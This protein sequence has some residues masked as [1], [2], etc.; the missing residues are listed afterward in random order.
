MS[1]MD[2]ED[3]I[4]LPVVK[5]RPRAVCPDCGEW[6]PLRNDGTFQIHTNKSDPYGRDEHRQ[7]CTNDKHSSNRETTNM[8]TTPG[9]REGADAIERR[10][11]RLQRELVRLELLPKD[12][13]ENGSV[14]SFDKS[15][16]RSIVYSYVA[17]K[18]ND[19]WFIS[20]RARGTD[21]EPNAFSWDSLLEF[22][23]S[24]ESEMPEIWYVSEWSKAE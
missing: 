8:A 17:I 5:R 16:G 14:I 9:Q 11:E 3:W 2:Y 21:R 20:G 4:D 18:A 24:R 12:D 15:F 13:Y 1:D 22:V 10:I 6:I 7:F 19:K 23:A